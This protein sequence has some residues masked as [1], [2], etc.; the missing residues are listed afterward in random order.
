MNI[1][2]IYLVVIIGELS[3]EIILF[4]FA[5]SPTRVPSF[6]TNWMSLCCLALGWWPEQILSLY[7]LVMSSA[8]LLSGRIDG[9]DT[10][11][12]VKKKNKNEEAA[13]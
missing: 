3:L 12:K 5:L 9:D 1:Q 4:N 11:S 6:Y 2:D 13:K 10:K 7:I 8:V